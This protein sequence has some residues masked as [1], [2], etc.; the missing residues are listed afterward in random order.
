ML[1]AGLLVALAA[2]LAFAPMSPRVVERVYSATLYPPLQHLLTPLA[3]RVPF[4]L[5]DIWIV[6]A[7][8]AVVGT[9]VRSLRAARRGGRVVALL[10]WLGGLV[11]IASAGYVLFL[12]LWGLNYR[13]V[14]MSARL[15]LSPPPARAAAGSEPAEALGL[16]AVAAL[17]RLYAEAHRTGWSRRE[18][19]DAA[20][21]N[22]FRAAQRSLV[23][24]PPATPGRLKP[25]LLGP[26]FRWTSIDGMVNPFGLDVLANPD[27]LPYERPFVAA[28]EWSHLAGFADESEA[29]FLG[30]LACMRG[31]VPAQY[32]GWLFLYWQVSG[33]VG[34]AARQRMARALEAGPRHDL[35]AIVD[36]LRRAQVPALQGASWAVYDQYLKANRV[37]AGVRSYGL[38]LTLLLRARFDD[39]WRPVRTR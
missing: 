33:E 37:D 29:N 35:D 39:Q 12:A 5:L 23:D 25:T 16:R 36:R 30:F 32:S 3:N 8:I 7:V 6:V 24:T 15:A 10:R 2:L 28:H 11:V 9:L 38:V 18:E 14:P 4:A 19:Q 34:T 27:L 21:A 26:W 17:N 1:A 13:R 22:A 20:F 31:P